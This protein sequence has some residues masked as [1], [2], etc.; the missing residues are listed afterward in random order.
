MP[1]LTNNLHQV[2]PA[3][4]LVAIN[5]L[6]LP[7][8]VM[9]ES[10]VSIC[11]PSCS[12]RTPAVNIADILPGACL[13]LFSE[14]AFRER[15]GSSPANSPWSS[16]LLGDSAASSFRD[17]RLI[18]PSWASI[19]GVLLKPR[20]KVLIL[21]E[22][23]GAAV[24][25]RAL[26]KRASWVRPKTGGCGGRRAMHAGQPVGGYGGKLKWTHVGGVGSGGVGG[27]RR[28]WKVKPG[29]RGG[30]ARGRWWWRW[31]RCGD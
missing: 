19:P 18:L 9:H 13:M 25:L 10:C 30:R 20:D 15:A 26:Y 3:Q 17:P 16:P 29:S 6:H 27:G 21:F 4:E 1:K 8:E 7:I 23:V 22:E 14:L 5:F 11:C 31:W 12:G 24:K 28:I 2:V